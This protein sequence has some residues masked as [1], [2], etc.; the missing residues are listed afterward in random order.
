MVLYWILRGENILT[1]SDHKETVLITGATTGIGYQLSRLFAMNGYDL[2]IVARNQS[3]LERLSKQWEK[4]FETNIYPI[5]KDLA[6]PTAVTEITND[7]KEQQIHIDILINNAGFGLFGS[8]IET[9][10][11]K[12]LDMIQVN[13]TALTELTKALVPGMVQRKKGK[14][15]N[16]ASVAAFQSGPL[17]AVYFATKAYVL[18][19]SEA[20]TNELSEHGILVSVLCP[21]PTATEFEK[22]ANLEQTKLFHRNVMQ[23]EEVARTAYRQF[24]T[25]KTMIVPGATNWI[26][27][28][29]TRFLPRKMVTGFVRRLSSEKNR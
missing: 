12:E 5:A 7:L 19:F 3:E 8:F 25:G 26:L 4:E 15:L 22:R 24:M 23:A 2:V 10:I 18:S 13:I 6:R 29:S 20:L 9:P 21:G 11:Q 14:I 27:V 1:I 28:R 17:M 16:V